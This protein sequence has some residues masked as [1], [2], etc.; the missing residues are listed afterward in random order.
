M[1]EEAETERGSDLLKVIL[2]KDSQSLQLES[3]CCSI[4]AWLLSVPD[5]SFFVA[6]GEFP[7][8]SA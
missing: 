3:R 2:S 7:N 5:T 4:V 8:S 6:P 1:V